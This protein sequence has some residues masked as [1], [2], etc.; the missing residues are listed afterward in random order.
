LVDSEIGGLARIGNYL[1]LISGLVCTLFG[2]FLLGW[3]ASLLYLGLLILI[4]ALLQRMTFKTF[5]SI[6]TVLASVSYLIVWLLITSDLPMTFNLQ[7]MGLF[8]SMLGIIG[9]A[10]S[11]YT[12]RILGKNG[13]IMR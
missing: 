11:I 5:A 9:G 12:T 3:L 1:S 13:K 2:I 4:T 7:Y 10:M 8:S 6:L